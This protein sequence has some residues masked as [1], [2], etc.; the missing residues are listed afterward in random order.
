MVV[1]IN[2]NTA[3]AAEIV[4]GAVQDLKIGTIVGVKSYGKGT[5]QG[6]YP[7]DE[8]NAVKLTVAKYK[9]ANGRFID[10]VGIEPDV[11][12]PLQA[13]DTTDKQFEKAYEILNQ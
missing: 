5:V 8:G 11:V 9:T 6:I 4:A 12:V 2:E 3:S 10:G 7:I 13:N 1:L